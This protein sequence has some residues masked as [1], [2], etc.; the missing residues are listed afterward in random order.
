[1]VIADIA[2]RIHKARRSSME[3]PDIRGTDS[4]PRRIEPNALPET[5][6]GP[7]SLRDP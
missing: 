1:M 5:P 4:E 6:K 7:A 2:G 3:M